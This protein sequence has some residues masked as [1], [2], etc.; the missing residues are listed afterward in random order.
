MGIVERRERE[1]E[2]VRSKILDAARELFMTEGYERVTM[3]RVAEAI[4]YSP[5]AIYHHFEDKDD[6]MRA[7]CHA[8]FGRLLQVFEEEAPPEDPVEWLR[9][10]ARAYARLGL[11]TPNHYRFM[12]LTPMKP[13][14]TPDPGDP[15]H[16]SYEVLRTAVVKAIETGAFRPANP[17]TVAQVLWAS[18]HGVVALLI[19]KR[20]DCWPRPPAHDLIEQTI[21]AGIR[22]FRAPER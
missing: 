4:E 19:T 22:A 11:E 16:Q 8:D 9:R 13:G 3:R 2:E 7:L 21:E 12:F 14:Y 1:R 18:L 20:P 15:G 10:L 17:D 6:L 5:T